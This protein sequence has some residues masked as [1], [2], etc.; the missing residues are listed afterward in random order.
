M[1]FRELKCNSLG[2]DY[3]LPVSGL[4]TEDSPKMVHQISLQADFLSVD[5]A[6]TS[7]I[8]KQLAVAC[9]GNHPTV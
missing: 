9:R 5:V 7:T 4:D 3:A 2:C 6:D 8:W 1:L